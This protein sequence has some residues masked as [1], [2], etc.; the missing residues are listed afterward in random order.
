MALKLQLLRANPLFGCLDDAQRKAF[1]KIGRIENYAGGET[2]IHQHKPAEDVFLVLR[3]SCIVRRM[4]TIGGSDSGRPGHADGN[5]VGSDEREVE[6]QIS[7]IG[8]GQL[9]GEI[10]VLQSIPRTASVMAAL[11]CEV[12]AI[13][14]IELLRFFFECP[15]LRAVLLDASNKYPSDAQIIRT[16]RHDDSWSGYRSNLFDATTL[17]S[18][19]LLA[20]ATRAGWALRSGGGVGGVAAQPLECAMLPRFV[21]PPSAREPPPHAGID[22]SSKLYIWANEY[23]TQRVLPKLD[24]LIISTP[25]PVPPL[26]MLPPSP[27][28]SPS[29]PK[30]SP[31][32]PMGTTIV[33]DAASATV[34]TKRNSVLK[35]KPAPGASRGAKTVQWQ[36]AAEGS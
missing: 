3:G 15:Q 35:Q 23:L 29:P 24:G 19:A 10:G 18:R 5:D 2:I 9:F 33:M 25:C 30:G 36:G 34:A 13:S 28:E 27:S 31:P 32:E 16:W 26:G 6:L 1:A 17:Q 8:R 11:S 7:V 14:R 4:I 22:E 20:G 21:P 12:F